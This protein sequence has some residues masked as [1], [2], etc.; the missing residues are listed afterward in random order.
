MCLPAC[1]SWSLPAP[2]DFTVGSWK[3]LSAG[4]GGM[5]M[6]C[7]STWLQAPVGTGQWMYGGPL[8]SG[9]IGQV[10]KR[11]RVPRALRERWENVFLPLVPGL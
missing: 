5:E 6:P 10:Q 7:H 4:D 8:P 11:K 2:P 9:N 3:G 1:S